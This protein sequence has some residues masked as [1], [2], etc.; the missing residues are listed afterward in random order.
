[1][2][3]GGD[4]YS[5]VRALVE[6]GNSEKAIHLINKEVP[7]IE[8]KITILRQLAYALACDLAL[9]RDRVP[10]RDRIFGLALALTR[11]LALA[12][13]QALVYDRA[14]A[15]TLAHDLAHDLIY[16][17][18]LDSMRTSVKVIVD[19]LSDMDQGSR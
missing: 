11:D 14:L 13:A 10:P 6:I 3:E 5:Q 17:H 1:M 19:V 7:E 4:F 12:L 16:A 8:E 18:D 9:A 2:D 15:L